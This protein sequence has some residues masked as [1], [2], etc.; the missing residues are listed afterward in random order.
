MQTLASWNE[1]RIMRHNLPGETM[2]AAALFLTENT[3]TAL[4]SGGLDSL[5]FPFLFIKKPLNEGL[6][7]G[8]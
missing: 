6:F 3:S 8:L 7:F 5:F 4:P 1:M 2:N